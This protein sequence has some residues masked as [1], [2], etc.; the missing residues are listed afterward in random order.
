MRFRVWIRL[1]VE[2][3]L[4]G[5]LGFDL[6]SQVIADLHRLLRESRMET[7][8]QRHERDPEAFHHFN[9]VVV[10]GNLVTLQFTVCDGW[11]VD[12]LHVVDVELVAG[13][14]V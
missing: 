1:A 14:E 7:R 12:R 5:A 13:E 4:D 6:A 3:A 2:Q 9:Q 10:A 8:Q 11:E